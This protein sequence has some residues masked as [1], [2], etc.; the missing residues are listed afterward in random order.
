VLNPLM[1]GSLH[2]LIRALNALPSAA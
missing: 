1:V 2:H